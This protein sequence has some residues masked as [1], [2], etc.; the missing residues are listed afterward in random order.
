[1]L[2][3]AVRKADAASRMSEYR[4]VQQART[5]DGQKAPLRLA[6]YVAFLTGTKRDGGARASALTS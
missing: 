1:M 3:D 4:S 6:Q 5:D 2:D